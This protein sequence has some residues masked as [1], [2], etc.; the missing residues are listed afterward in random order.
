MT[1]ATDSARPIF[2]SVSFIVTGQWFRLALWLVAFTLCRMAALAQ[3]PAGGSADRTPS[4]S[5]DTDEPSQIFKH[6]HSS[7]YWVSGQINVIFQGHPSFRAKY[8]GQNSLRPEREHAVSRVLTLYTGVELTKN[9]EL[10]VDIESAGGRGISD[11]LGLAGFTNLDVVRNPSLGSKPYLARLLVRHVIALGDESGE[12]ARDPLSLQT[13]LPVRR[14]EVRAGKFSL[15]DFFDASSAASDSHLQFM[16]WAVDNNG[17]FDYAANTR[18][19]TYGLM[20][21]YHDRR[22]GARFAEALM[23]RVANGLDLIWNLRRARAENLELELRRKFVPNRDGVL[24]FLSYVNHANMGNYREAVNAFRAG[25]GPVP[26]IQSHPP[27]V[28]VKYGFGVNFE[29]GI[30]RDVRAFGRWGW[31]EGRQESFV[32]TEVDR[33]VLV[34]AD[35]RG[36]RWH[37]KHDKVGAAL[38]SSGLSGDHRTYLAL[39]GRGFLLGDGRLTYGHERIVEGYY[40]LHLWRGA[41]AA[42]D[43]QHVTNPG[44]NRD[45]GPVLVLALRLHLEL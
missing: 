2:R 12:V 44:Y 30:T 10:L 24:R 16:N 43:L 26:D 11:A 14:L 41:F 8:T 7:R 3:A 4:Q 45:R 38:V 39:G 1:S 9:D 35:L 27:H 15:V 21:E 19:Y 5:P 31:N 25:A 29:Q 17:A 18:G 13:R 23:P 20:L 32:Y 34:G 37:R 42:F 22:W 36:E 28:R 6:S 33:T 40:N